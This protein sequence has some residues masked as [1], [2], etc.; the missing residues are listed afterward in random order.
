MAGASDPQGTTRFNWVYNSGKR[1][2]RLDRANEKDAP[3][4]KRGVVHGNLAWNTSAAYF[5]GDHHTITNNV[6]WNVKPN[7]KTGKP[8]PLTIWVLGP[9]QTKYAYDFENTHSVVNNNGGEGIGSGTSNHTLA[10]PN[11]DNIE[12]TDVPAQFQDPSNFDFRPKS[13]SEFARAKVGPYSVDG[14]DYWI[15][16]RREH[17]ASFPVPGD[18]ASHVP[19]EVVLFFRPGYKAQ[20]HK[21]LLGEVEG[22]LSPVMDSKN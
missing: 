21:V 13:G 2:Y 7:K 3:Y 15:P 6:V 8:M 17:G 19:R 10:G 14:S 18:G 5:K 20:E 1:G 11:Q 12:V 4:N 16:G 9:G 22:K